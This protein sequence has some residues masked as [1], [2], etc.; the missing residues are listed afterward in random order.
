MD[1]GTVIPVLMVTSP[2]RA[3]RIGGVGEVGQDD[4][5]VKNAPYLGMI[6]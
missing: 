5:V 6:P 3:V 4:P 2:L 1:S